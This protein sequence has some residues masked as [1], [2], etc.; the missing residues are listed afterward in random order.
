MRAAIPAVAWSRPLGLPFTE[1]SHSKTS[2]PTI[3]DGPFQGLP[4]G[5]FGAGTIGRTYRG[6]FARWH[7]DIGQHTYAPV[8]G[9]QF[10]VWVQQGEHK[11]AQVLYTGRP[12]RDV[13]G[14]W[15]WEYPVGAGTYYAL[16]PFTWYDY[17][18]A[19]LPARLTVQQFSPI[20]PGNYRETSY[21]IGI[22]LWTVSNPTAAPI[23]V[24]V[25]FTWQDLA[26]PNWLGALAGNVNRAREEPVPG[27]R[28]V[29]VEMALT[30]D[31][32]PDDE[33]DGSMAIAALERPGL[34]ATYRSRFAAGGNGADVWQDLL[35]DGALANLDDPTPA[36]PGDPIG[37]ALAVGL[38]LEAGQVISFPMA[39]AWDLPLMQFG[40]GTRWYKKYTEYFGR[41]G[42]QAWA[43]ARE[44]LSNYGVWR[45]E[46]QAWQEPIL[47][48]PGRPDW[49]K[50]ALF[51]ELY[52]LADGGTAWE[53]GRF[54][55]PEPT[56]GHFAYLECFDYNYYNTF[57]VGFYSSWPLLMLWPELEESILRDF[58]AAVPRTD[59]S[60]V[61]IGYLGERRQRK[62]AGAVP[63]DMGS[64]TEDPWLRPNAF[65][66]QDVNYWKDLNSKFVLQL[67]RD[68]VFTGDRSLV[69]SSWESARQALEYLRGF[70]R[71][72]DGIPENEGFP[73]Q[74]YD[75]WSMKGTSA[76]VGSLWLAA[77]EA[78]VEM[79]RLEEDSAAQTE[80][81]ALLEQ[82][83]SAFEEALWNGEYYEFDTDTAAVHDSI[84]ADQLIGQW[85]ARTVGLPDIVPVEHARRALRT[86]YEYNVMRFKE[87]TMG[88]VNGMRPDGTI[89]TFSE[90]SQEVWVGTTYALAAGMYQE[91]LHEEAW[92]TA[93]GL[94]NVT[95]VARGLWF[96]TPEAWDKEGNF[97]ASM[98]M[99]PQAIWALELAYRRSQGE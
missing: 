85:Y 86:I 81:Q 95:Y 9:N 24:T 62:L 63:H 73:D 57:D 84:M 22:F 56:P 65:T 28:M 17:L 76:Y 66:W 10:S 55:S 26:S 80:Y 88:A 32:T 98:Y 43:I 89:D 25:M 36:E 58:A 11:T 2:Y 5:G 78:A 39:L 48:D 8:W 52:Y 69:D 21:P 82:S 7:L 87:G 31:E 45:D 61:Q 77:L 14:A 47:A 15:Q 91:G 38:R 20:L 34:H 72:G 68:Y 75:T 6:D 92:Q 35:D 71:N 79:A 54:G 96:R 37:A 93:W 90:Q 99:R 41:D 67:Y 42:R 49:F 74:T 1:A 44:G 94:Y 12:D 64:P 27:G 18:H 53:A 23:S 29:G 59:E 51:N 50:M 16:Y 30:Q 13:L 46:I 40:A 60:Q 97:R 33:Y 19:D 83:R 4:L 3:D 70:D